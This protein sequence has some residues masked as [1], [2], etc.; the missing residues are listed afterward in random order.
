V[1]GVLRALGDYLIARV[2]DA[3]G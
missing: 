3:R 2:E 1:T